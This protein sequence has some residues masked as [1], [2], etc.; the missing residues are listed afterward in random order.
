M[1]NTSNHNKI[2][3]N[4][5]ILIDGYRVFDSHMHYSGTFLPK[6]Q[7]FIEYMDANGIDAAIV[8]TLNINASFSESKN[9][10]PADFITKLK[11]PD[12]NPFDDLRFKGQPDHKE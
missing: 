9:T 2:F 7:S 3:Y 8:N 5:N 10:S 12:F 4:V 6:G 11:N 1:K